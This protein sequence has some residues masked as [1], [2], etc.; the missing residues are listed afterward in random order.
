MGDEGTHRS[1][2]QIWPVSGIHF[3]DG[4]GVKRLR[5]VGQEVRFPCPSS[6]DRESTSGTKTEITVKDSN[7]LGGFVYSENV[8]LSRSEGRNVNVLP[9]EWYLGGSTSV[10]P[11]L[12]WSDSTSF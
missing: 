6:G 1:R 9:L 7:Y 4:K 11:H 3:L 8:P 2:P 12:L 10:E 5:P